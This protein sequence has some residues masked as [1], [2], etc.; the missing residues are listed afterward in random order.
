MLQNIHLICSACA[1]KRIF[2]DHSYDSVTLS[3]VMRLL[4]PAYWKDTAEISVFFS[5]N[6]ARKVYGCVIDI[7]CP[8]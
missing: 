8:T 6:K 3:Y 5:Q 4:T 1:K 7:R 2:S